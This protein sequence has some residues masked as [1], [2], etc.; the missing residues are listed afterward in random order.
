MVMAMLHYPSAFTF[1]S[2]EGLLQRPSEASRLM[3]ID[4]FEY[5]KDSADLKQRGTSK[6]CRPAGN[7]LLGKRRSGGYDWQ[8]VEQAT[9]DEE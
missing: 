1:V 4:C 6:R 9:E 8:P 7:S 5:E 3:L 2:R